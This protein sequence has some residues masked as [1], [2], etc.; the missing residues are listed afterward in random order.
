MS[1]GPAAISPL[2]EKQNTEPAKGCVW[3]CLRDVQR[4]DLCP[5]PLTGLFPWALQVSAQLTTFLWPLLGSVRLVVASSLHCCSESL[6]NLEFLPLL[7]PTDYRSGISCCL[8]CLC[9][10][11]NQADVPVNCRLWIIPIPRFLKII[12]KVIKF[13]KFSFNLNHWIRQPVW[14]FIL[15][16]LIFFPC[17]NYSFH[18]CAY[19]PVCVCM[20]LCV[21]S[22]TDGVWGHSW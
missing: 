14:F 19:V 18:V 3:S 5:F 7:P 10:W 17:P 9:H 4:V 12:F 20:S 1:Q 13:L 6:L 16:S 21:W 22:T 8:M 11:L 2:W 15:S